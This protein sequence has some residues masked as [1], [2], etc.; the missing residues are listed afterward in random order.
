MIQSV[1]TAHLF[2]AMSGAAFMV[3]LGGG[4]ERA[5]RASRAL[6]R[7]DLTGQSA[8]ELDV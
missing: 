2:D 4:I 7:R 3:S 1:E 8:S 5:N 6:L